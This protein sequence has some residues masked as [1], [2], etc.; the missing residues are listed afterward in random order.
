[1]TYQEQKVVNLTDIIAPAFYDVHWDIQDGNN[2][3]YDLAGGRGSTKSSF[4]STEIPYGMMNDPDANAVV[5]RKVGDTLR[6]SVFEQLLWGIEK[7]GV[8]HKWKPN[9]TPLKLTYIETGQEILFR[10]LDKAEKSKSIKKSK[11]Y[12]KYLW[13]EELD[14]FDGIEEIRKVEQS[15]MRGGSKF[16]VFR[17]YNPPKSMNNWVNQEALIQRN[18]T[19]KHHSTY[20]D[21]P[22]EWLG[23]TFIDEAEEL[24]KTKPN[25]YEHEYLGIAV[26]TGGQVFDNVT[27]REIS[28][29][30]IANFDRIYQGLDFGYA[31]DPLAYEKMYYNKMRKRLFIFDEIVAIRLQNRVAAERIKKKNPLN[32]IIRADSAEPKSIDDLNEHGLKVLGAKK[33]PGSIEFGIKWLQDLEEIIIDPVRCP[34]AAREFGTYELEKDKHGNFKG[35]YPD[36]DNH[37]ID[38]TRYALVDVM[39]LRKG[40]TR[41]KPKGL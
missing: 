24:K 34:N 30:E 39:T 3:H 23:Q 5:Y 32:Q 21:V 38:A 12:F 15:V 28:D 25:S 41:K 26:G 16:V 29:D 8:R 17:S 37:T 11:G 4:I 14:E 9:I 1:M 13:F 20:L 31:A 6:D 10:G 36:K 35:G 2:T 19:Y 18:D 33:G 40:K 22:V 27:I 7:L